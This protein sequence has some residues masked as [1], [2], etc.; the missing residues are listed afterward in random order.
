MTLICYLFQLIHFTI[1]FNSISLINK[2]NC[3][4]SLPAMLDIYNPSVLLVSFQQSIHLSTLI[5]FY[6][7]HAIFTASENSYVKQDS[8]HPVSLTSMRNYLYAC[9]HALFKLF[10]T[11]WRSQT[12]SISKREF[13]P[14]WERVRDQLPP[15]NFHF[16]KS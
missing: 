3:M 5:L 1:I 6:S 15:L 4:H 11:L 2:C 12:W 7:N 14:S 8:L 10:K 16:V 13:W 9:M